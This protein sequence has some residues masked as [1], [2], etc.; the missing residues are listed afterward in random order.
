MEPQ[1]QTEKAFPGDYVQKWLI[2]T[3]DI[4][5]NKSKKQRGVKNTRLIVNPLIYFYTSWG[6]RDFLMSGGI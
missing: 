4:C 3:Y 6:Y 1:D 5:Y 2:F